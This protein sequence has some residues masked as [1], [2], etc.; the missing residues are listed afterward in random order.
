MSMYRSR[1]SR[2][3]WR[4]KWPWS[5]LLPLKIDERFCRGCGLSY[6][7]GPIPKPV[8]EVMVKSISVL[9]FPAGGWRAD[10]CVVRVGRMKSGGKSFYVSEFIPRA[11]IDD[12]ITAL[13][14]LQEQLSAP[15]LSS[16]RRKA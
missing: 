6:H 9:V 10:D 5:W 16:A 14:M 11:E 1:N 2:K 3:R 12:A 8:H 13:M 15:R 7:E 4:L